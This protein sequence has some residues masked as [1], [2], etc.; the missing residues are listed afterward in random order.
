MEIMRHRLLSMFLSRR[1]NWC[2]QLIL[3]WSSISDVSTRSAMPQLGLLK[4]TM[5]VYVMKTSILVRLHQTPILSEHLHQRRPTPESMG[6]A[7][8]VSASRLAFPP[9]SVRS[10]AL[11]TTPLAYSLLALSDLFDPIGRFPTTQLAIINGSFVCTFQI[12]I[13]DRSQSL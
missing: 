2:A 6:V 13:E 5:V 7:G 4:A 10:P 9:S 8:C 12:R 11:Q 3:S 1:V